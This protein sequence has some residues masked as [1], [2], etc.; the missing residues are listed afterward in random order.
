MGIL[1]LQTESFKSLGRYNF[2]CRPEA[3][4]ELP[5]PK[6][7]YSS[8]ILAQSSTDLTYLGNQEIQQGRGG[9]GRNLTS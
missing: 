3:M 6:P 9:D 2:I 7:K 4:E 5:S 8:V 1:V